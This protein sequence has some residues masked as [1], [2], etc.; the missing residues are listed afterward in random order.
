M[1]GW[2]ERWRE[3]QHEIAEGADADLLQANKTR[4]RVALGL[5]G[6]GFAIILLGGKL[7]VTGTLDTVLRVMAG[8]SIVVGFV[9]GRWARSEREFLTRPDPEGPPEIFRD[10][11]R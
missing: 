4:F 1:A 10:K 9:L 6:F 2:L 7:H 11:G 5:F 3:R 8:A